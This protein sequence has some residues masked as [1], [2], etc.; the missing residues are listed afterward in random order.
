[1]P[2][3]ILIDCDPGIDDA[4]A[5][6]LALFDPRLDVVAITATAGNV[7]S[8]Q[9]SRNVQ[10]VLELLD[11]PRWPRVG[12]ARPEDNPLNADGRH[13][14]GSDGLGNL[15]ARISELHHPRSSDKVIIDEIR[16]APGQVTVLCL[17]PVTNLARAISA[18]PD[19]TT[20]VDQVVIAGGTLSPVGDVTAAAEFNMYCDP[21]AARIV[22]RS[23]VTK[24]LVPRDVTNRLVFTL[25]FLTELP[26]EST[27]AGSFVRHVLSYLYRS[28]RQQLGLEGIQL[29]ETAALIY[30]LQSELFESEEMAGDVE[31]TGELTTGMTV[32]DRRP[33]RDW[34]MNMEVVTQFDAVEVREAISRGIRYAAQETRTL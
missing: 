4:V 25:D 3:K 18:D 1:M 28:Y 26:D 16:N 19:L 17:G 34:R 14:N 31:V 13:L 22:L 27:R 24:T 15:G 12:A 9:S 10:T 6:C 30:C 23:P 11:P 32:Y 29:G 7:D 33:R 2:R 8:H 21:Q 5:M 20:M